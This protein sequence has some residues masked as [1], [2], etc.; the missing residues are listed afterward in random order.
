VQPSISLFDRFWQA[1]RGHIRIMTIAPELPTAL[2]LIQH[3]SSL[4][5]VCSLGHTN[6]TWGKPQPASAPAH[7]APPTPST[8]CAAWTIAILVLPHMFS[9]TMRSLRSSSA[10]AFTLIPAMVRLFYKAKGAE[11]S[12]PDHGW[13]ERHG[14]ARRKATSWAIWM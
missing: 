2:E 14:H 4:G 8:P 12:R 5:V 1:A 7:A 3:A 13:H 9:T 11:K 10:T 6:A